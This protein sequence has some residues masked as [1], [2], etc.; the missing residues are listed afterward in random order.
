MGLFT[1]L[2]LFCG[3]GGFSKGFENEG[4]FKVIFGIDLLRISV[5]TFRSNHPD[6]LAIASDIRAMPAERAA[7]QL[8]LKRGGIDVIIGGPPCQGFSSI[9]PNRSSF[10]EDNRNSLFKEFADYVEYFRPRTFVMENVVG[11]ATYNNGQTIKDIE[12]TFSR[13]GYHTD[14]RIINAAH[15]G[16]PQKRERLI[17]LGAERGTA[18]SFPEPTH[19]FGGSTI[20]V[21]DKQRMLLPKQKTLFNQN[22]QSLYSAITVG[23]AI[24]DLPIIESGESADHYTTL[25]T[26]ES[27]IARRKRSDTLSLHS[28]TMHSQKMLEIIR[29]SGPNISYIP[30]HLITSGFS[31]CYSRLNGN[32]PSVTITV[33]FVHPASNRCIHPTQNRALTPRE[34]ARLQSF[35]D[36]FKFMGSRTEIVKQIGNAVP[37][38][39]GRAIASEVAAILGAHIPSNI[40][41]Q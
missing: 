4:H 10:K 3:T 35:D 34:G 38:L 1:V 19:N 40:L 33:N 24:D 31:S 37:P 29:Y 15:F 36:D 9:R 5:E 13:L 18:L 7:Q 8:G 6:A 27:Q 22:E 12:T 21:Q 30:K 23:D 17:M 26:T 20:G 39:L 2:D 16:V 14:W 11:L 28:S 32:E 25:S 41:K